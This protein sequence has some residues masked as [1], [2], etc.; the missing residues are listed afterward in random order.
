MGSIIICRTE[1]FLYIEES[2]GTQHQLK[3]IKISE[4]ENHPPRE[5][6]GK[7]S[8]KLVCIINIGIQIVQTKLTK[9]ELFKKALKRI[10]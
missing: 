1:L 2:N 9:I 6:G 4:D 10:R 8:E 7:S 5:R 3:L